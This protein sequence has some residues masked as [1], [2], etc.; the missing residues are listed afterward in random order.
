MHLTAAKPDGTNSRQLLPS[1]KVVVLHKDGAAPSVDRRE[2]VD[3]S[4][5]LF[6]CAGET[7]G[8]LHG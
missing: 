3:E 1:V 4:S 6:S 7:M 8:T 2:V 5:L